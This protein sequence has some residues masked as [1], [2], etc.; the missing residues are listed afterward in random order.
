LEKPQAAVDDNCEDFLVNLLSA[1]YYATASSKE[2]AV[3]VA[4]GFLAK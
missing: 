2:K 3:K 4:E 1:G